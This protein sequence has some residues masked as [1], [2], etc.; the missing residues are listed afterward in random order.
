MNEVKTSGLR[1]N[2]P[3]WVTFEAQAPLRGKVFMID[4]PS[5]AGRRAGMYCLGFD[6]EDKDGRWIGRYSCWSAPDETWGL[7]S[8]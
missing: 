6:L 1:V 5:P 3:V 2:D 8:G 7:I 4:P